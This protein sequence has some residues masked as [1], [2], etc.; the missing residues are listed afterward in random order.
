L[1]LQAYVILSEVAL[2]TTTWPSYQIFTELSNSL[3]ITFPKL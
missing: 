3:D 1:T 2:I